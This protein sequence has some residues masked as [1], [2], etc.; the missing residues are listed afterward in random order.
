MTYYYSEDNKI[1]SNRV[2]AVKYSV[3]TGKK[4]YL[5]YYDE[6]YDKL[7]WKIEPPNSLDYY[8]KEQA[9]R[10][11]DQYEYLILCCSGGYD[12]TN[13]LETFYYNNIKL[14]KIVLVGAFKQ[15]SMSGSDENHNGELYK[16]AYPYIKELGL[17]SITQ[18]IDYSELFNDVKQFSVYQLGEQ[19]I[20]EIGSKYS[21][22]NWFWKDIDRYVVPKNKEN[23]KVGII[24]GTDKPY[25]YYDDIKNKR[26]FNFM[27]TPI[28]SYGRF[29]QLQRH[30][31]TNIN[32]YWDPTYPNILLKQLHILKSLNQNHFNH[33]IVNKT[34]Y[35]LKKPLFYKSPKSPS[36]FLSLRDMFLIN[37]KNSELYNFFYT[38]IKEIS[39]YENRLRNIGSK[40]YDIE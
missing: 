34:I 10:I 26:Y 9:Q 25:M 11:R 37:H 2:Q 39:I 36:P 17:E 14:D 38:G 24:F 30:N 19:W 20:E 5:Y 29:N 8:Y 1:F 35:N 27:D 15:D 13:I 12:S 40:Q 3:E 23:K 28:V 16:N 32:F 7:N 22:H 18:T 6:I 4:V 31:I 21:P 33:D